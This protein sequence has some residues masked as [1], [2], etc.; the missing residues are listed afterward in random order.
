[1]HLGANKEEFTK[2]LDDLIKKLQNRYQLYILGDMNIDFLKCNSHAQTEEYQ[3]M[4]HSNNILPRIT[5]PTRITNHTAT[6]IDHIYT[7]NINHMISGIA[8]IDISDHLPTFCIVDIPV[9]KQKFKRYYR[10]YRRFDSE[11]YLQDIKAI[12]W[13][14][15]YNESNDLNEI[16]AKT[17]NTVQLIVNKHAPRKQIS[18]S[19]QK[20]FSKPWI[21]NG[22]F[23]SIKIK[24]NMYRTHFLSNDPVKIAEYKIY[25]NKLN[26][27]KTFSKKVHYCKQFNLH[28]NNPKAT[29]KLIG[30]LIKRKTKGQ[31][32]PSRI[33]SIPTCIKA[34]DNIVT[35]KQGISELLNTYFTSVVNKLFES[36]RHARPVFNCTTEELFTKKHFEFTAVGKPFVLKQLKCL[37]PK[38]ATGLDGLPARLLKDS[39]IVIAD[40]VTHLINLSFETGEV[41]S[42]W[43]QA[44][45]VPLFKSGNKDDLDNYRP[46]SILPILSKILEKAVFHQLHSY[47]SENSL[48]SPYQSG[49]R[50][51]HST[52]LAVTFLTDKIRG[53]MDK[54]LLTGAVFIDLKK[55]FD[56]VPHDGLLNK[57]Y[58]YGIQDH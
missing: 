8:T 34:D 51:N 43:K 39:A 17:I 40:C 5:K 25:A 41:P 29:W 16:A 1:M 2:Q 31:T 26:Q 12:D 42:E 7:N 36:C 45:V 49:F 24:Q 35:D 13:N 44:K 14:A 32:A 28:R 53:H 27:L 23:K 57:L 38:K 33:I 46:I 11:L 58:R 6:L 50:A 55:A 15:I 30:T 3:D 20:Q 18:R 10:D 19:K 47:L 56:T 48:L 21:T 9:Q 22:I 37:K 54:G 52:Q 4:L